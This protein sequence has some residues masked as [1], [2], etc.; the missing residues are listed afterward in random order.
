MSTLN[1]EW[2]KQNFSNKNFILFN[3]GCAD[4]ADDTFRFQTAIPNSIIY[5]FECSP[6]WRESNIQKSKEFGFNY[7][8]KAVSYFD[9]VANFYPG[10]FDKF[11]SPKH[12]EQEFFISP[13]N[14]D[15]TPGTWAYRGTLTDP[16]L[17][18]NLSYK[19]WESS[20]QIET[21]SLN[22]FCKNSKI[23]PD[24][25]HMDVEREEYNIIFNL[26]KLYWPKAVW[27]EKNPEYRFLNNLTVSLSDLK[28]LFEDRNYKLIY[29][30]EDLL[31]VR[32]DY[33][34]TDYFE[35]QSLFKDGKVIRELTDTEKKIQQNMWLYRY[36]TIKD[37]SWPILTQPRDFFLL[38]SHIQ[39]E[40]ITQFNLEPSSTIL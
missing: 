34:V 14:N 9:G 37:P 33:S 11:K 31:F 10:K 18:N 22:T 24:F 4:I 38:P 16:L 7:V 25:L 19:A 29:E 35:I 39:I 6:F 17:N 12:N 1:L 13:T 8:H 15:E 20:E 28:K 36:N 27:L 26:D 21:I 2:L 5:S 32:K 23:I 30:G 40:C 3:I